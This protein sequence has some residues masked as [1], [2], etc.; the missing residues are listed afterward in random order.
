LIDLSI[1]DE[2]VQNPDHKL[3]L[4]CRTQRAAERRQTERAN[5]DKLESMTRLLPQAG[6]YQ[7]QPNVRIDRAR[8][9]H[10]THE[11]DNQVA[12]G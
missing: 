3:N 11:S 10:S 5:A 4:G 7:M 9:L 6:L 1:N 8:R 2:P 12:K